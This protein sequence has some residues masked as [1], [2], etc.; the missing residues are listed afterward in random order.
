L[1][2]GIFSLFVFRHF[3]PFWFSAFLAFLIFDISW[4]F[5]FCGFFTYRFSAV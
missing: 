5:S 1:I 3:Q 2:F 4:D